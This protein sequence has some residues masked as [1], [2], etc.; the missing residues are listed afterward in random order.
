MTELELNKEYTYPQICE[1]IGWEQTTGNSRIAQ[2]KEIEDAHEFYHPVNRKTHKPK[3]SYIFTRKIREL[4]EPSRENSAGNNRK[5]IQPMIDYLQVKFDLD[6]NWYSFT[7][8]YCEKLE[9]MY[10]G[11]CNAMYHEDEIDAVC[12]ECNISDDRLFFEYVSATKSELKSMFLKSLDYL[13]KKDKITYHDE[14]KFIYQLGERTRGYVVTDCL[15]DVVK[16]IETAVCNDMNEEH[17]LSQKMKGRQLLKIIYS[18][19]KLTDDFKELCLIALNDNDDVVKELNDK[20]SYQ[21]TTFHPDYGSICSERPLVD[22]RRGI[23]INDME[24]EAGDKEYLDAL[25]LD[26]TNQIRTKVRKSLKKSYRKCIKQSDLLAIEKTLFQYYD[27]NFVDEF[28]G[29]FEIDI[30]DDDTSELDEIFGNRNS[31]DIDFSIEEILDMPVMGEV[32]TEPDKYR[33]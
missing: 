18:K 5:N 20:L 9:L 32:Q 14:Y 23:S 2:I 29:E 4:V 21:H 16:D 15:N 12:E 24:I 30:S 7:D 13:K 17:N 25:A 33:L 10:K 27:E 22:Y 28:L 1:T 31:V 26:V 8:W 19:K 11:I 3:K 6:D